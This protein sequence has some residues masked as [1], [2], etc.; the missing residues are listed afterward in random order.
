MQEQ[1]TFDQIKYELQFLQIKQ[2]SAFV[3][4]HTIDEINGN[5]AALRN[6]V[7]LFQVR[8]DRHEVLQCHRLSSNKFALR[9]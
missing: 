1:V 3:I 4:I 8:K 6:I 2:L 7:D 9:F 5:L